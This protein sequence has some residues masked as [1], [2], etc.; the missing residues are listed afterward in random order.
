MK[1]AAIFYTGYGFAIADLATN[2][3]VSDT[4]GTLHAAW[5]HADGAGFEVVD[6]FRTRG[7]FK[8]RKAAPAQ[9]LAGVGE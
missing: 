3:E 6:V 4:F 7:L 5:K 8:A 9:V 2:T 1:R